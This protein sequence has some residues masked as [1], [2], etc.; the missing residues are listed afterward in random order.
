MINLGIGGLRTIHHYFTLK[1]NIK[2]KPDLIIFLIGVN[3]WNF[4]IIN[5]K[6][7]FLLS[8]FEVP[9]DFRSSLLYKFH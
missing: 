6:E 2:F 8:R 1:R 5:S 7:S 4:Q 9:F 3:D